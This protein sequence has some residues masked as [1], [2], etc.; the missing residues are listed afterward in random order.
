MAAMQH[1]KSVLCER[2][3]TSASRS[4]VPER[5]SMTHLESSKVFRDVPWLQRMRRACKLLQQ[6]RRTSTP[7]LTLEGSMMTDLRG[8]CYNLLQF[9]SVFDD[10]DDDDGHGDV[11]GGA[12]ICD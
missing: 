5:K 4:I 6:C 11:D 2:L 3:I 1:A 10:D 7:F 8:G 9:V 12:R